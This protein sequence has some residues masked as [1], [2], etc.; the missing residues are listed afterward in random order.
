MECLFDYCL[1]GLGSC[2]CSQHPPAHHSHGGG[3]LGGGGTKE[4]SKKESGGGNGGNGGGRHGVRGNGNSSSSSSSSI[5]R[6]GIGSTIDGLVNTDC[7]VVSHTFNGLGSLGCGPV[8]P[9]LLYR[10]WCVCHYDYHH[11]RHHN[12]NSNNNNNHNSNHNPPSKSI[13][14]PPQNDDQGGMVDGAPPPNR[15]HFCAAIV[16]SQWPGNP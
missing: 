3:S 8:D 15:S 7:S 13:S 16:P 12:H 4:G 5:S 2:Q 1:G 14:N 9:N 11:H 6:I 10:R